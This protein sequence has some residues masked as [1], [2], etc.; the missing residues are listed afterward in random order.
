MNC[1]SHRVG[2]VIAAYNEETS[3]G[4]VVEDVRSVLPDAVIIVVDDG[5]KDGTP[6]VLKSLP[7]HRLR[8]PTNLGQGAALQ[9]GID[10]ARGIHVEYI[11]TFDA[12]GQH[13][14][15]DIP[16]MLRPLFNLECDIVLGSRFL[17]PRAIQ[18]L[19]LR[20]RCLL[21]FATWF[22]RATTGLWLTDTHNGLRAFRASVAPALEIRMNGMSHAS[23]LLSSIAARHLR[24]KEVPVDI[25]YTEYSMAKGQSALNLVNILWELVWRR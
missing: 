3:I 23:E 5:S 19:P 25:R 13:R 20:R 2:I 10:Y 18:S 6:D 4:G 21:S 8:H 7:V 24:W 22:T 9:T 15:E 12:D 17:S 11:V 16:R 1:S 14:A